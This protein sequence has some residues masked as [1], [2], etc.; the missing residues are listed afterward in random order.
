MTTLGVVFR[1]QLPPERLRALAQLADATGIEELWLW[2]DC[3][4]EGVSPPPRLP[5]PGPSASESG[6]ACSPY[7]SGMSR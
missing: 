2:E 1:P 7:R 3:F 5:S 4:R 6:S